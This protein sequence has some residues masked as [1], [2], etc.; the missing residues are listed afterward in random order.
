MVSG[1]WAHQDQMGHLFGVPGCVR[2]GERCPVHQSPEC[3]SL[4]SQEIDHRLRI[5]KPGIQ[6]EVVRSC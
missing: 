3:E 4:K 5:L 1:V 2:D 6:R